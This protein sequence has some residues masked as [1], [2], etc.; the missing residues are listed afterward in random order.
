MKPRPPETTFDFI[1]HDDS[2]AP[3]TTTSMDV[4]PITKDEYGDPEIDKELAAFENGI[5]FFRLNTG[6]AGLARSHDGK[7]NR[8]GL[9]LH[10]RIFAGSENPAEHLQLRATGNSGADLSIEELPAGTRIAVGYIK[11]GK[12]MQ[13]RVS[14]QDRKKTRYQ[15]IK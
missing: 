4:A 3:C 1:G 10:N 7:G 15:N 14:T 5:R 13:V 8:R 2:D 6:V 12:G 11:G 9:Y